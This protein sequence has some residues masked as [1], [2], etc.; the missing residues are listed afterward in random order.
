MSTL[1]G[2]SAAEKKPLSHKVNFITAA[3]PPPAAVLGAMSAAGFEVTHVYGLTETY[4]PAVLNEWKAEWDA[5]V[6]VA[7]ADKK[8]RQGVR[9][10]GQDAVSVLDP[11]QWNLCRR[12]ARRS[13]RS[14]SE[15][16]S[17]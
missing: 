10:P 2:A 1:L 12:M 7:R 6:P 5:L 15:A 14:C 17:A 9:Y 8:A 4:G 13:A 3:A 16:I 11:R